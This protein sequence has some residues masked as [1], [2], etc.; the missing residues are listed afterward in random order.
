[1]LCFLLIFYFNLKYQ[2]YKPYT[3]SKRLFCSLKFFDFKF[4]KYISNT[5]KFIRT[6]HYYSKNKRLNLE[7]F[8]NLKKF[9]TP[10]LFTNFLKKQSYC[11]ENYFYDKK[12]FKELVLVKNKYQI[13]SI[14]PSLTTF[15]PG[16]LFSSYFS[17]NELLLKQ[18][19]INFLGYISEIP[20]LAAISFVQNYSKTKFT[21]GLSSGSAIIKVKP[22][23]KLKLEKVKLS[24]GSYLY[25]FSNTLCIFGVLTDFKKNKLV[26][27]KYGVYWSKLFTTKVRGVAKNPVDH[28]NGGRTKSKSP[29]KSPWGWIAKHNC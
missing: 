3:P 25:L 16:V 27:G 19:V 5:K 24:S 4:K 26:R 6:K 22:K 20:F 28:P 18:S 2:F 15:F 8:R 14:F 21:Y 7:G 1:M 13:F 9:T 11:V 17:I 23:K 12:N 10:N 29:E